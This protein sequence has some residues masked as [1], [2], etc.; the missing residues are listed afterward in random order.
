MLECNLLIGYLYLEKLS[1]LDP[2]MWDFASLSIKSLTNNF[3]MGVYQHLEFSFKLSRRPLYVIFYL[4]IPA[5]FLCYIGA[6]V[7]LVSSKNDAKLSLATTALLT[8]TVFMLV[9]K[10]ITPETSKAIPKLSK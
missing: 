5:S 4:Y 9:V 8:V 3:Q 7:F 10:D 1:W 6:F 2:D